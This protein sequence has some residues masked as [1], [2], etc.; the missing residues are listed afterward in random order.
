MALNV[1]VEK[2]GDIG[3]TA[4]PLEILYYPAGIFL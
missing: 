2:I 4:D 3:E 1:G